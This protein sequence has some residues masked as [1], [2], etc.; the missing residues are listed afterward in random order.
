MNNKIVSAAGTAVVM[1]L[2]AVVLLA[3]GYD[4][5]DPP[6][7]EE[8]VEV[9]LGDSDYGL[10]SDP[11]PA[12]QAA[13]YNPPSAQNQVATQQA[14]PS[15]PMP[16]TPNQGNVT[17]PSAQEQPRAENKEPEINR[18]AL[19]P[20][21]RNSQGGGSEGTSGGPGNQGSPDGSPD[22]QA[23]TGDGGSGSSFSLKGRNAV[24]LPKPGYNSNQQGKVVVK[25]VVDRQGRVTRA[26]A[27]EKG[28]T[29]TAGAL[30]E[31][32]RQAA[33]KA[34]FNASA[35]APDEQSGTITYIFKI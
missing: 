4:P 32:A 25:I 18:N 2:V 19:F 22:A 31:Q 5:P 26:E 23:Y 6:I 20:G 9:N 13:D 33:L 7:P 35:D 15:V 30:V 17:N 10:G 11:S 34:R 21:R 28:S 12:S 16:S 1:A 24:S 3:F 27:P 8:G 29:I 14:E